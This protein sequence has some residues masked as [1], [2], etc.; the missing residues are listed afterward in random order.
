[1]TMTQEKG[2]PIT[3]ADLV[4]FSGDIERYRHALNRQ[5]I[6]TSGVQFLAE[7]GKC[8]WLIDAIA[9]HFGSREMNRAIRHDDRVRWLQFW[10]LS[11]R[12]DGSALLSACADSGVTPFITQE[13]AYTD[14]PLD[15]VE[16][17]AGFDGKLWTLYL[18]S[19]H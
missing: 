18:P 4:G 3:K 2:Q 14:F 19:E 17:W 10:R 1:M 7:R 13:I 15:S 11:V 5:V 12:D 9:S 16:I 8:Y 6:Y